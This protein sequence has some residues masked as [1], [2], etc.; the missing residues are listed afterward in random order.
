MIMIIS[1]IIKITLA[2]IIILIM[3]KDAVEE[4]GGVCKEL[5]GRDDDYNQASNTATTVTTAAFNLTIEQ[6]LSRCC[7]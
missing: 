1:R 7:Y 2:N 3:T 4:S 5:R 6:P